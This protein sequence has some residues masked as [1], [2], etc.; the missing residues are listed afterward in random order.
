MTSSV[1][2]HQVTLLFPGT[3]KS[4][5]G[6]GDQPGDQGQQH[7]PS[8]AS[9]GP[10]LE[11]CAQHPGAAG[12]QRRHHT[13]CCF[14]GQVTPAGE[15]PWIHPQG[16]QE[17]LWDLAL[18]LLWVGQGPASLGELWQWERSLCSLAGCCRK[19][20]HLFPTAWAGVYGQEK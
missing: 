16:M 7:W 9:P 14:P 4:V 15:T 5:C 6:A 12:E 17:H 13:P 3:D 18:A 11:F 20:E 10:L 8:E 2:L 1:P 19:E